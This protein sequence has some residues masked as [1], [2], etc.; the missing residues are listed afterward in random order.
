MKSIAE[1][2]RDVLIEQGRTCI[3][4]GD[5]DALDEI[6][7]RSIHTNLRQLHIPIRHKRILDALDC[8]PLFEKYLFRVCVGNREGIARAFKLSAQ[9]KY[10][11]AE[12]SCKINDRK[13]GRRH[14]SSYYSGALD[15]ASTHRRHTPNQRRN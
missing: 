2:A 15:R 12:I 4:W 13:N 1:H 11:A 3:A 7:H 10:F 9:G 6:S 8:S 5:P 14:L